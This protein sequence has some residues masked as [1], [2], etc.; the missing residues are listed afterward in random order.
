[1][2]DL[3]FASPDLGRFCFSVSLFAVATSA[4]PGPVNLV[5]ASSGACFGL[6]RSLAYVAGASLGFALLLLA[7]GLGPGLALVR[8]DG[9][10]TAMRLLGS[11]F[12]V[13]LAWKLA[14]LGRPVGTRPDHGDD[15]SL[16]SGP[17]TRPPRWVDG[18]LA[19]WLNPKAWIVAAAGVS[20][21]ALPGER[22]TASIVSM[23]GVFFLICLP[24]IGAWAGGGQWLGRW[25][26]NPTALR[27]FN[28]LMAA[29]LL[30]S[31]LALW[32]D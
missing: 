9:F 19:Q 32:S 21:Y 5:A 3:F 23:S 4:S 18:L 24:S 15:R 25:L 29:T 30:L 17:A 26:R 28:R 20:G 22:Y 11:L 27:R 8:W 1:M 16:Q 7:L 12:L 2:P 31:V 14:N 10:Q 6:R 13:Y